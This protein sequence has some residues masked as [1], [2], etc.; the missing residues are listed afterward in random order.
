[1]HSDQS[2]KNPMEVETNV[3]SDVYR[4]LI[5][6]MIVSNVLFAAGIVQA[7]LHPIR[8][9][10][11]AEWVRAQYQAGKVAHGLISGDAVSLMLL[12]TA[13]LILT[14]VARVVVSIAAFLADRDYKYVVVTSI[15]LLVMG[16]TVILGLFGLQ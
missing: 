2:L 1:V 9:P 8:A 16:V 6:G 4:L 7:F 15:V 3:Y 10:L 13:L 5:F 12:A 11:T 14:P